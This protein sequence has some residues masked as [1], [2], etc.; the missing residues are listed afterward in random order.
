M[1]LLRM[2]RLMRILRLLRLVKAFKPLYKLAIGMV[3]AIQSMFWVLMLTGICLYAFSICVTRVI[4]HGMIDP[5]NELD[6]QAKAQFATINESMFTLFEI[7]TGW[8]LGQILPLIDAISGARV[9]FSCFTIYSS[10]ALMSVMAGVVSE[11]MISAGHFVPEQ[12]MNERVDNRDQQRE[13]MIEQIQFHFSPAVGK[14]PALG[15]DVIEKSLL[16]QLTENPRWSLTAK[17]LCG[18]GPSEIMDLFTWIDI[19]SSNAIHKE[20]FVAGVLWVA[21]PV[22]GRSILKIGNEL[23]KAESHMLKSTSGEFQ[24][25]N[26]EAEEMCLSS[27]RASDLVRAA[28]DQFFGS[29]REMLQSR[30][31]HLEKGFS[32]QLQYVSSCLAKVEARL[33]QEQYASGSSKRASSK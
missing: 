29:V 2:A 5:N 7:M 27:D 30:L 16:Q 12:E 20:E 6:H 23:A 28:E 25:L 26:Q 24:K 17:E 21:E 3:S 15:E 11:N 22:S 4:G 19:S 31:S 32:E 14:S 8:S 18:L 10:W 1:M 9:I 13:E 33:E